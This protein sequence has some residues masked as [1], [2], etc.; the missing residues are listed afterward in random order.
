[1]G[2]GMQHRLFLETC[3][4]VLSPP[5]VLPALD[6]LL[7]AVEAAAVPAHVKSCARGG[8]ARCPH[9]PQVPCWG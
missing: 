3:R 2:A 6:W 5:F 7:R 8:C 4:K 1:M 9:C